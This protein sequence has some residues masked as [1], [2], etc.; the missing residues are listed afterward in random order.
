[1]MLKPT[2]SQV[3]LFRLHYWRHPCWK[4][5]AFSNSDDEDTRKNGPKTLFSILVLNADQACRLPQ[6]S[7]ILTVYE[8]KTV[9]KLILLSTS[10]QQIRRFLKIK[11]GEGRSQEKDLNNPIPSVSTESQ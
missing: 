3:D 10:S 11:K 8:K 6:W 4:V 2:D 9:L 5:V 1:M 7:K